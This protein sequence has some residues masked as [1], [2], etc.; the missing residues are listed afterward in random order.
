MKNKPF[1][2][3]SKILAEDITKK[4]SLSQFQPK[5]MPPRNKT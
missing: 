1:L 2:Y 4:R 3:T 5:H